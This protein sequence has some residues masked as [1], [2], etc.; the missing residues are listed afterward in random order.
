MNVKDAIRDSD[1]LMDGKD[2][3]LEGS[4]PDGDA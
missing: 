4:K 2:G 1:S 3:I